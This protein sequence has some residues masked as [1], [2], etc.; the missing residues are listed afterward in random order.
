M[1]LPA[2]TAWIGIGAN[3]GDARANVEQAITA[4]ARLHGCALVRRSSLYRSA[5]V[6]A[7]GDDYVNA[8]LQIST[9]LA[10]QDLLQQ[11]MQLETG[12]GRERAYRN[13]PRTL[14]LDLL[15]VDDIELQSELLTLPHPRMHLRA[16]V[17]AP[18]LEVDPDIVIPGIGP[19]AAMLD[20]TAGQEIQ[21]LEATK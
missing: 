13:A 15:L 5:P 16:F 8:V 11:L 14:D 17:L 9:T 18:L 6:D 1:R 12:F 7:G 20:A 10:P 4:I 2:S 19:A 21:K 3:L